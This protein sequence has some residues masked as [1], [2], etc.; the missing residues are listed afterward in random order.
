[1]TGPICTSNHLRFGFKLALIL[2][3]RVMF[4]PRKF[5]DELL[6]RVVTDSRETGTQRQLKKLLKRLALQLLQG[7]IL[8]L[9]LKL[10]Q[11]I[12]YEK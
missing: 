8:M 11:V 10:T 5:V 4:K 7:I 9:F 1:M 12:K 6:L 3:A 2:S